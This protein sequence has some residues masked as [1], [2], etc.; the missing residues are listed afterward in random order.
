MWTGQGRRERLECWR[1]A[2]RES[3]EERWIRQ[4]E[5]R[6]WAWAIARGVSQSQ[7]GVAESLC[8]A[9]LVHHAHNETLL[10]DVVGGDGFLILEDLAFC[11]G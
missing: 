9:N 6:A 2:G 4:R 11:R 1:W 7:T 10:L 3:Q 5:Q 8:V